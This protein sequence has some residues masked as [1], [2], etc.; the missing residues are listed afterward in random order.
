MDPL[1]VVDLSQPAEPRIV[2]ELE[3]PGWSTYL[4]PWGDRL[5]ACGIETNQTTVS[6]FNVA[7]PSRPSL[8]E[9]VTI[10]TG[11]SWS[12][13]NSDEKAF[14]V[15]PEA[16]LVLLPYQT[17]DGSESATRVQLVDL[18]PDDL[19]LRGTIDHEIVPRR[20]TLH[21]D[22][23]ISVSNQDLLS[24]DITDRD[25]PVVSGQLTLAW[26]VD[27]VFPQG[28]FLVELNRGQMWYGDAGATIIRVTPAEEPDQV[29]S[30]AVLP[31]PW[32]VLGADVQGSWLCVIQGR[33]PVTEPPPDRI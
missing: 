19:T 33:K 27:W 17:W 6:L 13:A 4:Q 15:L 32:P 16:G 11:W 1:W 25:H 31:R 12:E 30:S 22:R 29:L 3:I 28:D 8:V 2:G 26:P 24:A 9:R 10:G 20:A 7:D 14:K 23:V 21:G 5:V 18:A